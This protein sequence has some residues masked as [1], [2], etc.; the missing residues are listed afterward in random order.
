MAEVIQL[1]KVGAQRPKPGTFVVTEAARD[2]LRSLRLVHQGEGA[3][4]T[5][6]AG[7]PGC[8]KS[9]SL[10]QFASAERD[11]D[12]I[13]FKSGEDKPSDVSEV[14]LR[15]FLP[16]EKPNGMSIPLRREKMMAKIATGKWRPRHTLLADEAQHMSAKG[17]EWLRGLAEDAGVSVAFAG[18]IRLAA[19]IE[20][21]PQLRSRLIRPVTIKDV[22]REDVHALAATW[23]IK[24]SDALALLQAAVEQP[25][26]LRN[27]VNVLDLA[28]DFAGEAEISVQH[29][30]AAIFDLKLASRLTGGR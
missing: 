27:L 16:G 20:P 25:G 18:D 6:I 17:I 24:D 9:L 29:V 30:R 10:K 26:A 23:Q 2:I 12:Y 11:V 5:M 19:L 21:I 14:L 8:G 22:S 3:R 28:A 15:H 13:V 7:L 1:A 4:F